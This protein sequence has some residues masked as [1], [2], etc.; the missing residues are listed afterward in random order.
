LENLEQEDKRA[1]IITTRKAY[2]IKEGK[3]KV[4]AT[5]IKV[6]GTG[7]KNKPLINI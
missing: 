6:I 1:A 5:N 3:I 2:F 7:A 4:L